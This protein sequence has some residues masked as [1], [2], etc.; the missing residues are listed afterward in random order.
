MKWLVGIV[1]IAL[2]AVGGWFAFTHWFAGDG[3]EPVTDLEVAEELGTRAVTLY[4]ARA[5]ANGF[6]SETRSVPTRVHRES[7][8]ETVLAELLRG[9]QESGGIDVFP[10]GTRLTHAF[11]DEAMRILYL[12][13]NGALVTGIRPGSASELAVL[14]SLLR[15]IAL[16]FPEVESVQFLVSGREVETLSGHIDLTRPL[17]TRDWL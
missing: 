9:P 14:G 3:Q 6:V 15:T 7:E 10:E 17:R 16:G 1:V 12:D 5:D 4:F 11:F 8:V 13:F 2:L